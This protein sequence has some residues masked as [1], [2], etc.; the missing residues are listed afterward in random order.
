V[1]ISKDMKTIKLEKCQP[2]LCNPEDKFNDLI[3]EGYSINDA[4]LAIMEDAIVE[5]KIEETYPD[6][7]ITSLHSDGNGIWDVNLQLA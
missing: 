1:L 7:V 4:L 6:Y 3:E 2:S 5:N